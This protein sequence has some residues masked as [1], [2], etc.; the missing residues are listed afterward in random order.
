MVPSAAWQPR[1]GGRGPTALTRGSDRRRAG[2]GCARMTDVTPGSKTMI[3]RPPGPGVAKAAALA[4]KR[5]SAPRA[6][7]R[8]SFRLAPDALRH[9]AVDLAGVRM[10]LQPGAV[11][12]GASAVTA[13]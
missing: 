5:S 12:G 2:V 13:A 7:P 4:S 9:V 3:D 8:A 10:S 6:F 11:G 1:Q